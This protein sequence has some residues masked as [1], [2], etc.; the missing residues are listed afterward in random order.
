MFRKE[1][2][3]SAKYKKNICLYV[4]KSTEIKSRIPKH[5]KLGTPDIWK[6]NSK[7]S[8]KKPNTVSQLRIGLERLFPEKKI[9]DLIDKIGVSWTVVDEYKNGI[10]RFYLEN[11][12][13][14]N[15]FP[16]LNADIER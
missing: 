4:G 5:L 11:Y 2:I 13:I 16:L 6:T 9:F 1:W 7:D 12:F 15:F 3:D 14:G 10:N 8:G